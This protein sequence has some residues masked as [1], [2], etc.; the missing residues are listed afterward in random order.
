MIRDINL[1]IRALRDAEIVKNKYNEDYYA[2]HTIVNGLKVKGAGLC[3]LIEF[4]LH[5]KFIK[6]ET[7]EYLVED[8]ERIAGKG[9]L[10][11]PLDRNLLKTRIKYLRNKIQEIRQNEFIRL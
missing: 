6:L 10:I 5:R 2:Y 3:P 8:F 1:I 4:M 7:Y 9:K 11:L